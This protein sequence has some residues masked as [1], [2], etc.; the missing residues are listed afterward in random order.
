M[1]DW[2]IATFLIVCLIG[3]L[4]GIGYA[5]YSENECRIAAIHQGMSAIEIQAVCK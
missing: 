3:F 2:P 4:S 1:S 5:I